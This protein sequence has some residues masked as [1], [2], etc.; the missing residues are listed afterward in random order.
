MEK[1]NLPPWFSV[2]VKFTRS[3]GLTHALKC[4][5]ISQKKLLKQILMKIQKTQQCTKLLIC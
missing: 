1:K 3:I 2:N 5:W 4:I